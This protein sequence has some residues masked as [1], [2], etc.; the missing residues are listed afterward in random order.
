M[1]KGLMWRA[2]SFVVRQWL[3]QKWRFL[4]I[5]SCVVGASACEAASPW[6]MTSLLRRQEYGSSQ[7]AIF[8]TFALFGL[9]LF[10]S[11]FL[12]NL[13]ERISNGFG[14]KVMSVLTLDA[15]DRYQRKSAEW[16]K[17]HSATLPARVISR[18]V[19]GYMRLA[20]SLLQSLLPTGLIVAGIIAS[21]F[22]RSPAA[23]VFAAVLVLAFVAYNVV[24]ADY[25]TQPLQRAAMA[26]DTR[27][28][29]EIGD[30]LA[31]AMTVKQHGS[32]DY[33]LDRLQKA[34]DRWAST[35]RLSWVRNDHFAAGQFTLLF[36]LQ[37]GVVG[38]ALVAGGDAR[39]S[40][41][42]VAFAITSCLVL[43]G[44]VGALEPMSRVMRG[45]AAD[46]ADLIELLQEERPSRPS[47]AQRDTI[48][49]ASNAIELKEV[50]FA[51]PETPALFD[52]LNL[53]IAAGEK[54]AIVGKSGSGKSTM[55]DLIQGF[56]SVDR[57][58]VRLCG[59][60]VSA[61]SQKDLRRLIAVVPQEPL[62]FNRTVFENI[63]YSRR[64]ASPEQVVAAAQ[65]AQADEFILGLP[66]GYDTLVGDR[67]SRLSGG[68]RQ[69]IAIARAILQD[70][71]IVILDEATSALDAE[72]ESAIRVA[73]KALLLRKTAIIVT[74][75]LSMVEDVDRVIVMRG[76]RVVDEG[77]PGG[78]LNRL[79]GG[80]LALGESE[81]RLSDVKATLAHGD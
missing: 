40:Y 32:E 81:S 25:F 52:G 39:I 51:Y 37:V 62:L 7:D 60:E 18:G 15:F 1:P 14:A 21:L 58:E 10:L 57:G 2:I 41:S 38:I 3:F 78:V 42:E 55:I 46:A 47:W 17:A 72:T 4:A 33:E 8:N 49:V 12:R 22:L 20:D 28:N 54:V 77:T 56:Y 68:E 29:A 36:L 79:S 24:L 5:F 67:G 80:D 9:V 44:R 30:V 65:K 74:H 59:R 71:P 6:L 66:D 16:H 13:S 48:G 34:V 53:K 76:G 19:W 23:G 75:R 35:T 26:E 69:R 61:V 45:A 27:V 11:F 63:A 73:L 43:A 70:A 31:A 64:D 50:G